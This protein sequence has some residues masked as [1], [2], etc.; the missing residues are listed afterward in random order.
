VAVRSSV[1]AVGT[2]LLGVALLAAGLVTG[3]G[4]SAPERL[5]AA[6]TNP[7]VAPGGGV[8]NVT[9]YYD[10]TTSLQ[11]GAD[12]SV[13]GKSSIVVTTPKTNESDTVAAI[14]SAGA[15]AYRY[16]QFY[17]APRDSAYEGINLAQH[18]DWAF[19]R[20]GSS[21]LAGRTAGDG[22][23]WDFIDAN[24]RPVRAQFRRILA[25]IK[26]DGWDGVMFDRGQAAT[27][28]AKDTAGRPVWD[29]VSS[30]TQDP[31][32]TGATFAD[33]YV[34]ML[35]LAHA[36][37]LQAMMNNGMSPFDPTVRMRP[38]PRDANC[39]TAHWAHCRFLS[40][41]WSKVDLVLNE[42]PARPRD[43]NWQSMFTANQLSERDA[44]HGRRTVALITTATL[45]G[46]ANQTRFNVFYQ[47]SRVKLFDLATGVNTGDGGCGPDPTSGV[48]NRQG[49]YPELVDTLMGG[50]LSSGPTR[51][52]CASGSKIH[53]VWIRRYRLGTNIVNA[54]GT[55]R[56]NVRVGLGLANCRYVYD[57]YNRT[58][59]AGNTCKLAVRMNL[60]AWSGRPLR[61]SAKPW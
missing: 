58:P 7:V 21:P 41:V 19:C 49:V 46:A 36:E 56:H 17:W 45:G 5:A 16:I 37:G 55:A 50:P 2:S 25:G 51:Q 61:F 12:L 57:V 3:T 48:C 27:Q 32:K 24:E 20:S 26:A 22:T 18:P 34:N 23:R 53:C 1:R 38:D 4:A 35:A 54:Q 52:S 59:L 42:T 11:P 14:H 8:S 30:C 40:D 43:E 33:A 10:G 60:P 6:A 29:R 31:Y 28:G 44:H 15:K 13:L 47:W 9:F 39:R